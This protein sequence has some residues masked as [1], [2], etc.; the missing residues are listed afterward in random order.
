MNSLSSLV[1]AQNTLTPEI[2]H[3]HD[4][5]AAQKAAY[6]QNTVPSA[7]ERI[8]RLARL[9]RTLVKYQ[10]E[11][12]AAISKD[13]GNR[14]VHETKIGEILTCIEQCSYYSKNL[15]AWMK[16]S[17]RHVSALHQPAKAWVQY[18][19]LGVIGIIAPWNYPLVLSVGPLICA[20]AAGNQ[21][22]Y[23]GIAETLLI[24]MQQHN[25]KEENVLYPMCDQH[26]PGEMPELL[27]RLETGLAES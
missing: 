9:R 13:Y 16:P 26:L 23:L 12:A 3:M 27:A 25:M 14:S 22:D 20:L 11:I 4:A 1:N 10:D 21:D 2:Q 6:L 24:M 19:P 15:T 7:H 5:L 18:Q 17:K 8:E